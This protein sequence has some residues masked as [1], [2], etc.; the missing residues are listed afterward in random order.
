MHVIEL[1][2]LTEWIDVEIRENQI[3]KK[4]QALQSILHT[5]AQP[6]Q[7]HQPFEPQKNELIEALGE[8]ALDRLSIDQLDFLKKLKIAQHIGDEGINSIEDSL[9]KNVIDIATSASNLQN[10]I[11][12]I[13]YGLKKSEQIKNGLG[14]FVDFELPEFDEVLIRVN[15]SGYATMANVADFKKWGTIWYDIARGVTMAHGSPPE[16]VKIIGAKRGSVIL[17]LAVAYGVAHTTSKIILSALKV[18]DRVLDIRKKAEEI[19][20]LK[21]NNKKLA[22]EIK[23]AADKEKASGIGNITKEIVATL[24]LNGEG[25]GEKVNALDK[26]V[27]NLVDFIEKG[28]EVDFIMPEESDIEDEDKENEERKELKGL[29]IAFEEI[30]RLEHKIKQI[31]HKNP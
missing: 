7:P 29:R 27:I 21:L 6:N 11:K 24:K 15:F 28:G 25:E 10:I 23:K 2:Q 1:Y 12:D 22:D 3:V 17:E 14:D 30:R 31:E 9:Y 16:D 5:N 8:V 4:Y 26:S 19:R 18:A 20:G 13:N